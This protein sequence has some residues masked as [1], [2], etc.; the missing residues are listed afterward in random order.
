[1]M[2]IEEKISCV[3]Q[4]QEVPR[5]DDEYF[6]EMILKKM[7]DDINSSFLLQE[8]VQKIINAQWARTQYF[9]KT[10]F[11]IYIFFYCIPMCV[12]CF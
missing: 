3:R 12:Q 1:M 8:T 5:F 10:I 9:Q 7:Q 4:N 6:S 11:R 2:I